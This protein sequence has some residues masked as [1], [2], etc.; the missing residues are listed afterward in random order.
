MVIKAT[1]AMEYIEEKR[2]DIIG[3]SD[4]DVY[5]RQSPRRFAQNRGL[6]E[7]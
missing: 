4:A 6:C 5:K 3:V 7:K 2:A 1:K